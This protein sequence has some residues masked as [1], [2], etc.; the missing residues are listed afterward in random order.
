MVHRAE[1]AVLRFGIGQGHRTVF[2]CLVQL[3]VAEQRLD[4]EDVRAI[5]QHLNRKGTAQGMNTDIVID[6][7]LSPQPLDEMQQAG[8]R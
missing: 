8:T 5:T 1:L 3:G 6:A 7:G 2:A 4:G